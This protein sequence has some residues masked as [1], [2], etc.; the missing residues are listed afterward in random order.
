MV[1]LRLV[2]LWVLEEGVLISPH[3]L[4]VVFV[5]VAA[6]AVLS[7]LQTLHVEFSGSVSA[8]GRQPAQVVLLSHIQ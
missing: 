6:A 5:F 2:L 7:C 1:E 4:V 8:V 3:S